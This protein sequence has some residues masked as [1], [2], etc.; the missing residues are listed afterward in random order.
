MFAYRM[1]MMSLNRF[2]RLIVALGVGLV[3]V[4]VGLLA[5]SGSRQ[6]EQE[7]TGQAKI[8]CLGW[9]GQQ[10]SQL[11]LVAPAGGPPTQLTQAPRNITGYKLSSNNQ[12][13][14]YTML[15]ENGGSDLWQI[16][17]DGSNNQL[18]LAC[19]D[20]VC[21]GPAWEPGDQRLIYERRSPGPAGESST[22]SRLWWL[23]PNSGQTA[24]V[25]EDSQQ[26]ESGARFS[27]DGQWL[28]YLAP[29]DQEIH[30]YQLATGKTILI[31]SQTGEMAVWS[32]DSKSLLI[33]ETNFSGERFATHIFS[34]N[35]DTGNLG[36]LS[37]NLATNDGSPHW[38][39]DGQWIV[40]GR[41]TANALTGKQL[42]LMRPDGSE[43]HRLTQ[44]PEFHFGL[45]VWSPDGQLLAFQ[46]Y[47]MTEAGAE[48]GV[49]I[50]AVSGREMW[51]VMT[52]AIQPTWVP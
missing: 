48:P 37:G 51:E 31:P 9:D 28:S 19:T 44:Q 24:P 25:F 26:A 40:F 34:L 39:P 4:L 20:F 32:P 12:S 52:P 33:S 2:N 14:A 38:S 36:D 27:P 7:Q 46:R 13:I 8:L 16:N 35:L 18:L 6:G 29:Q 22:P 11:Y 23:E 10:V 21:S 42:W 17:T 3:V 1:F 45:P 41:K 30:L 49:W 50:M 43:Q 5:W 47:P 15:N